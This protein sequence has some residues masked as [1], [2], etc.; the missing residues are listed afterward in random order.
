MPRFQFTLM[1]TLMQQFSAAALSA[2]TPSKK[3]LVTGANKVKKVNILK[4]IT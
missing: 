3:I 4:S 2:P 1:A